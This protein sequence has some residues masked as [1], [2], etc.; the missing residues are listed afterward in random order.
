[1]PSVIKDLP[2]S[3]GLLRIRSENIVR[4]VREPR[5]TVWIVAADFLLY[6]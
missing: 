4:I 1:M 2:G 3:Q 5:G 6:T